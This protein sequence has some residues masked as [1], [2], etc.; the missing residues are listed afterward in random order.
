MNAM[1][2]AA[3][4]LIVAGVLGLAYGGFSYTKQT[5]STKVGPIEMSISERQ[6]VNVPLWAGVGAIVIGGGLLLFGGK[7]R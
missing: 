6:T 3:I 4:V 1:R 7:R 2:I 5:H